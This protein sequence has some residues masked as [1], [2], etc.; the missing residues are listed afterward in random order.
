MIVWGIDPG[1]STGLAEWNVTAR[2]LV[3][4]ETSRIVRA[5]F[6]LRDRVE[7]GEAPA[8]VMIEDARRSRVGRDCATYGKAK[9]LQGVG[10]VKRDCTVWLEALEALAVPYSARAPSNTKIKADQFKALTGWAGRTSNH[11]RDA[12]MR[13]YGLNAPQVWAMV[14]EWRQQRAG[15]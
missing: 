11:G 15:R 9:R 1:V 3:R 13:V 6:E 5:I 14:S 4:V 2:Q 12:A 7:R 8:L 10:S